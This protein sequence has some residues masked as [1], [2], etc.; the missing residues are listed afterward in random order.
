MKVLYWT[1][2]GSRKTPKE[3][4]EK[5]MKISR[6]LEQLGFILRTGD[7]DGADYFFR[8]GVKSL[9]N[10]II[11]TAKDAN[12]QSMEIASKIH[13]A[14]HNCSDYAKKLHGRN[15]FQVL[16]EDFNSKSEFLLCWTKNGEITGGTATAINLANQNKITVFNFGLDYKRVLEEFKT[17]LKNNYLKNP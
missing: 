4:K 5:F 1:G 12:P 7:A 15:C 17:Y 16:G 8:S 3:L 14:W 10:K 13:P 2:V 6:Y 9:K 11:Y